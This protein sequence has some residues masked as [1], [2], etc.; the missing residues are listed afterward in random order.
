MEVASNSRCQFPFVLFQGLQV[1]AKEEEWEAR[2]TER[3][4]EGEQWPGGGSPSV[5]EA[6]IL[7]S[8]DREC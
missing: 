2:E 7:P 8:C 1:G 4:G 3:E 5:Q 6:G